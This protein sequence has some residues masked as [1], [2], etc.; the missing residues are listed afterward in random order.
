MQRRISGLQAAAIVGREHVGS[1]RFIDLSGIDTAADND[2]G[3]AS[4]FGGRQI[5][6]KWNPLRCESARS[7]AMEARNA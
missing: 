6:R 1:H 4:Q 5:V 3:N 2:R 7:T